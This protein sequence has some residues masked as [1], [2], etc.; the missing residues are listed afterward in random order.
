M[1]IKNSFHIKQITISEVCFCFLFVVLLGFFVVR[2]AMSNS[3]RRKT[4]A[5]EHDNDE[6]RAAKRVKTDY[7]T[8]HA[9][10][11]WHIEEEIA[12]R[13]VVSLLMPCVFDS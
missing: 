3:S 10:R 9:L 2:P 5:S 1:G 11:A 12:E 13:M 4:P 6:S 7:S 8:T